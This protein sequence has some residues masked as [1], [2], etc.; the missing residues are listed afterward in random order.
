MNQIITFVFTIIFL[1]ESFWEVRLFSQLQALAIQNPTKIPPRF[2]KVMRLERRW[3]W[4]SWILIILLFL[5]NS[6][7]TI[8][9]VSIITL[10]ETF[11]IYQ[12]DQMKIKM[13]NE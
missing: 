1:F 10:I 7:F 12:M 6:H 11:V 3:N 8:L 2:A 4:G 13:I 5:A 9:L